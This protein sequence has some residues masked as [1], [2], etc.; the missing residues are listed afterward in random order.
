MVRNDRFTFKIDAEERRLLELL[1]HRLQRTQS[2]T[3]R[4][5]LRQAAGRLEIGRLEIER[6]AQSPN[7][8][9]AQ[10]LEPVAGVGDWDWGSIIGDEEE[11]I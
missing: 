9:I 11:P 10:S 6:F 3:M 5:L 1:A 4:W 7:R 8:L 2:D